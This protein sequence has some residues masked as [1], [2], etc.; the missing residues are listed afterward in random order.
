M[1]PHQNHACK[2]SP[3]S[4]ICLLASNSSYK[5]ACPEN[6]ELEPDMHTCSQVAKTYNIILSIDT[7]LVSITQQTFGAH[8]HSYAEDI[9]TTVN[10]MEFNSQNGEV[11]VA[12]D[13]GQKILTVDL[14]NQKVHD[15][16]TDHVVGVMSMGYGEEIH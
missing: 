10:R 8:R 9:E 16:V 12:V 1:M 7:H 13:R 15:L 11:F 14:V 4:H 6:M 2:D 5:C 3:C